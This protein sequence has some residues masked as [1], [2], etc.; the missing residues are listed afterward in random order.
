MAES[1]AVSLLMPRHTMSD[2]SPPRRII[3]QIQE[4][5]AGG[6]EHDCAKGGHPITAA[7]SRTVAAAFA[8]NFGLKAGIILGDVDELN[9]GPHVYL[10]ME[11][12][13]AAANI[14]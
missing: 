6:V 2:F 7:R 1:D 9:L 4:Q 5:A 11:R 13:H 10:P 12:P 14:L 8:V 3:P